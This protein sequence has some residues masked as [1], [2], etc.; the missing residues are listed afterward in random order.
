MRK[1]ECRLAG[2]GQKK[3]RPA[4]AEQVICLFSGI[5]YAPASGFKSAQVASCI[6]PDS[7]ARIVLRMQALLLHSLR[8]IR[9]LDPVSVS[10]LEFELH[11]QYI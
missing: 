9:A 7:S 11:P 3:T 8:Y 1:D 4:K 6:R 10:D 2:C 5:Y